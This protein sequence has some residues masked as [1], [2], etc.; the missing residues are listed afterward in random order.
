MLSKELERIFR[1]YPGMECAGLGLCLGWSSVMFSGGIWLVEIETSQRIVDL[2]A[3]VQ[4]GSV[5]AAVLGF[6]FRTKLKTFF[7]KQSFSLFAG[8]CSSV[9]TFVCMASY[10]GYEWGWGSLFFW[11]T[12]FRVS[13]LLIGVS[14]FVLLVRNVMPCGLL[15]PK[16]ATARIASAFFMSSVFYFVLTGVPLSL[17]RTVLCLTPLFAAACS[18]PFPYVGGADGLPS[19]EGHGK[20]FV[21]LMIVAVVFFMSLRTIEPF[22]MQLLPQSSTASLN[23]MA[24]SALLILAFFLMCFLALTSA[25]FPFEKAY[26]VLAGVVVSILVVASALQANPVIP[27]FLCLFSVNAMCL[28]YFCI[29]SYIAYQS[30][31]DVLL[32]FGAGLG[33]MSLGNEIGN[34]IGRTL[35]GLATGSEVYFILCLSLASVCAIASLAIFPAPFMHRLLLPIEEGLDEM[36]RVEGIDLRGRWMAAAERVSRNS[37][38][39]AREEEVFMLIAKG[40]STQQVA[41]KLYISPYT[42]KAHLR[43]IYSK[44]GVNSRDALGDLVE[45][46]CAKR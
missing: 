6:A 30:D 22:T 13:C 15:S 38:L 29:L 31:I 4:L 16:R 18:I 12:V 11:A 19:I 14:Q 26:G 5:L 7:W 33:C 32:V 46:E 37:G 10:L 41:D 17:A 25:A 2:Y 44:V 3:F 39:S 20:P 34:L 23:D 21:R 27:S 24:S 35:A 43:S 36:M 45:A 28:L 42:V 9:G 1:Q 40:K 8:A